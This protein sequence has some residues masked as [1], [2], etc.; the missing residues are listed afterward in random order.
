M[1]PGDGGAIVV[2]PWPFGVRE[3]K[4]SIEGRLLARKYHDQAGLDAMLAAAPMVT[5]ETRLLAS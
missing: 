3:L 2:D 4:L 5:V 1:T